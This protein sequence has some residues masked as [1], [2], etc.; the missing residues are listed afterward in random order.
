MRTGGIIAASIAI[1]VAALFY[2]A[3]KPLEDAGDQPAHGDWPFIPFEQD[4]FVT[5]HVTPYRS[6]GQQDHA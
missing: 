3:R 2:R 1:A 4:G 6:G 5:V